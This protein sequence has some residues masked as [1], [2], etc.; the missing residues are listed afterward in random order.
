MAASPSNISISGVN[1]K[2]N[3]TTQTGPVKLDLYAFRAP[4]RGG[5]LGNNASMRITL[6]S[7]ISM[8]SVRSMARF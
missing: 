2:N 5:A 8:L 1:L 4:Y 6:V 3:R 7:T